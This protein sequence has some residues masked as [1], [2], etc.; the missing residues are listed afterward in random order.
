[1]RAWL[2]LIRPPNLFTAMADILAGWFLIRREPV[3]DTALFVAML[4]SVLFYAAG[5][6]LNDVFDVER[7]R[8]QRPDRPIPSGRVGLG[9][10]FALGAVLLIGAASL[11]LMI[12]R[13]AGRVGALLLIS[14]LAYDALLKRTF[15]APGIMGL[16][17]ALNLLLGAAAAGLDPFA[18]TISLSVVLVALG[19]WGYVT[20]VTWF[21]RDEALAAQDR[22]R[23]SAL[24]LCCAGLALVPVALTTVVAQR[25]LCLALPIPLFVAVCSRGL[26][27]VRLRSPAAVQS[28][29]RIMVL[30]IVVLDATVAFAA[31]GIAAGLAT[32]SLL[33]PSIILKRWHDPT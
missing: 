7:D 24:M 14:V 31:A 12:S 11:A 15:A 1:M 30:G 5:V 3:A 23:V 25:W 9:A 29:V 27:A 26:R 33:I 6:V 20:G 22:N 17:R 32:L 13:P 2:Q 16:C 4:A 10:A 19:L 18:T 21:A 28:A 8:A